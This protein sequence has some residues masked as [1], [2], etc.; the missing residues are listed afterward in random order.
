MRKVFDALIDIIIL[1]LLV[2][3]AMVTINNVFMRYL[4][5]VVGCGAMFNNFK[6]LYKVRKDKSKE[7]K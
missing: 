4:L 3:T 5:C 6:Y 2:F 1:A 7:P